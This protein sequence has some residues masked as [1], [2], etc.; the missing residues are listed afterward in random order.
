MIL[1][2]IFIHK[3]IQYLFEIHNGTLFN[4]TLFHKSI[5]KYIGIILN[6]SYIYIILTQMYC[7]I[8]IKGKIFIYFEMLIFLI[9]HLYI[10]CHCI[11]CHS[12]ILPPEVIPSPILQTAGEYMGDIIISCIFYSFIADGSIY[13]LPIICLRNVMIQA[14]IYGILMYI[15]YRYFYN[16]NQYHQIETIYEKSIGINECCICY[17]TFDV[18]NKI[19]VLKCKHYAHITCFRGW[20]NANHIINKCY[21]RCNL[22]LSD[23]YEYIVNQFKEIDVFCMFIKEIYSA[24]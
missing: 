4:V 20:W 8:P 11:P 24:L 6:S 10:S 17:N 21:Y 13:D 16:K 19:L 1:L 15:S 2:S 5:S 7:V 14:L 18:D 9:Y 23:N 22:V 12:K 3:L